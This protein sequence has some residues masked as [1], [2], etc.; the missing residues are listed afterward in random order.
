MVRE[1]RRFV[2][3]ESGQDIIEVLLIIGIMV[4]IALVVLRSVVDTTTDVGELIKSKIS[5]LIPG[6]G[7]G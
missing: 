2:E 1:L 7:G 5:E 4:T 3:D 6:L